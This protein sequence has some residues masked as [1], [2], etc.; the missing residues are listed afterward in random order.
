MYC[1]TNSM[2]ES[3]LSPGGPMSQ[4]WM[5]LVRQLCTPNQQL[6]VAR[7]AAALQHAGPEAAT[8]TTAAVA[9]FARRFGLSSGDADAWARGGAGASVLR[10]PAAA[11]DLLAPDGLFEEIGLDDTV[12][13]IDRLA[14][15]LLDDT[16]RPTLTDLRRTAA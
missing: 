13:V 9:E 4:E 16:Q 5:A 10:W 2:G 6:A 7:I 11:L 15:A 3:R 1:S 8:T 12:A 14:R